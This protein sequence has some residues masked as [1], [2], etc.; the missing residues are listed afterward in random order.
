V[1]EKRKKNLKVNIIQIEVERNKKRGEKILEALASGFYL[2]GIYHHCEEKK[3]LLGGP[4][5]R[6]S[7][8]QKKGP[9]ERSA[10]KTV[11]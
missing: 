10:K 8:S 5:T 9:R 2:G 7:L 6:K 4:P 1:G 3:G 11:M